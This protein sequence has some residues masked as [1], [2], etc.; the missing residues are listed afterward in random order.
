[1]GVQRDE[2]FITE[3]VFVKLYNRSKAFRKCIEDKF[4]TEVSE[5]IEFSGSK[6]KRD[7]EFGCPD[8]VGKDGKLYIEIKTRMSTPLTD[9]EKKDGALYMKVKGSFKRAAK[10]SSSETKGN[11]GKESYDRY[12]YRKY[13]KSN[14]DNKLLYIVCNNKYDL[15][16][17]CPEKDGKVVFMYWTEILAFLKETNSDDVFIE[18]IESRVEG[19]EEDDDEVSALDI[20][21]KLCKFSASLA[22]NEMIT[23]TNNSVMSYPYSEIIEGSTMWFGSSDSFTGFENID[24]IALGV[25]IET[26]TVYLYAK[27]KAYK[28][29]C[30]NDIRFGRTKTEM[31][32]NDKDNEEVWLKLF[33]FV[34]YDDNDFEKDGRLINTFIDYLRKV[35]KLFE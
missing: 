22:K 12:G 29:L 31:V 3:F 10:C 26:G 21:D 14:K 8:A 1:M 19:L 9:F 25:S 20:T 28:T 4:G 24:K 17:A 15:S 30:K 7:P 2:D 11:R 13:L 35:K 34:D 18:I 32:Q 23:A 33:N 6:N 16:E 5:E 27:D